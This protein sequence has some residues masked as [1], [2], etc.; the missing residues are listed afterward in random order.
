MNP[1]FPKNNL[2]LNSGNNNMNISCQ[3]FIDLISRSIINNLLEEYIYNNNQGPVLSNNLNT[4]S[5]NIISNNNLYQIRHNNKIRTKRNK[6]EKTEG[7]NLQQIRIEKTLKKRKENLNKFLTNYRLK[8]TFIKKGYNNNNSLDKNNIM[9]NNKELKDSSKY[10]F[11]KIKDEN[12]SLDKDI[13]NKQIKGNIDNKEEFYIETNKSLNFDINSENS[14][15]VNFKQN[16]IISDNNDEVNNNNE[17]KS[18]E[19][20]KL[21]ELLIEQVFFSKNTAK[22]YEIP[23]NLFKEIEID[24]YGNCLY[25]CISFYFYNSQD[26][27]SEIRSNVF[28]YINNN[29][30]NFIFFFKKMMKIRSH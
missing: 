20:K 5:S 7:I 8:N 23:F 19:Y 12:N 30:K 28:E 16:K 24:R 22:N 17:E 1:K 11:N 10:K 25:C 14:H 18:N 6:E 2:N 4:Q 27:H 9:K 26:H 13:K 15:D 21:K 3:N 29:K